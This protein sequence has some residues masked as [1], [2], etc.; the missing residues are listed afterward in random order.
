MIGKHES[1]TYTLGINADGSMRQVQI[2]EYLETYGSQVRYPAWRDQ[3]SGKTAESP[4]ELER[5]IGNI[6]GA[7]LSSR[8]LTEGI[9]RLLFLHQAV[10]R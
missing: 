5:D 8:H 4:L 2:I 10:L 3:F 9:K 6:T 7:T 1:I